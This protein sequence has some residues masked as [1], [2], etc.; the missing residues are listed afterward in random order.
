RINVN[1]VESTIRVGNT[2]IEGI[3]KGKFDA[4]ILVGVL[5]NRIQNSAYNA[6]NL[7]EEEIIVTTYNDM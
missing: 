6:T 1:E 4:G 2:N 3:R 5:Y 7:S